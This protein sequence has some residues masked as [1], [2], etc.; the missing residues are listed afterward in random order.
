MGESPMSRMNSLWLSFALLGCDAIDAPC[1]AASS[2]V[3]E[4]VD[5]D[6]LELEGGERVRLLGIDAPE[7]GETNECF[8][9][10]ATAWLRL[11]VQD[12]ELELEYARQC[13]DEYG[14]QLAWVF[15]RGRPL[16]ELLVERGLAC[17]WRPWGDVQDDARTSR[18]LELEAIARRQQRGLWGACPRPP[19][20]D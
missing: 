14:R 16:A 1:G 13:R 4:V 3:V 7:D 2:R 19:C 20:L 5:G 9:P 18:L 11:L 17:A 6:T 12:R 10:E 15:V 8:G